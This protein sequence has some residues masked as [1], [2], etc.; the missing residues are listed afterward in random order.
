MM[1]ALSCFASVIRAGFSSAPVT[2]WKRRLKSSWRVSINF[3][4]SS[5]SLSSRISLAF[6]WTTLPRD[7]LRLDGKLLARQTQRIFR[8]RLV[9]SSQLEHDPPGLCLLYT[10]DAAD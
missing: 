10:S 4:S 2:D 3:C 6:I 8:K 7:D 5:A 9:N 1:S